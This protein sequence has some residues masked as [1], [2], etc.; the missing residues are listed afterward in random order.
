MLRVRLRRALEEHPENMTLMLKGVELLAKALSRRAT[1]CRRTRRPT[2]R[3]ASRRPR[4]VSVEESTR[5]AKVM[6][7][8]TKATEPPAT[9]PRRDGP[10]CGSGSAAFHAVV[11]ERLRNLE[12]QLDEVKGR[13]NG[14]IFLIIG[15]V[16]TQVVLGLVQ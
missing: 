11:E 5:R 10:A 2:S 6:S 3:R 14:L 1:G 16:V 8:E 12:K 9:A 4:G 7:P 13:V 15:V